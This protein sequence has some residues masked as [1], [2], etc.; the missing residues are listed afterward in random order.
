M[1]LRKLFGISKKHEKKDE[2]GD[3]GKLFSGIKEILE[4]YTES[5]IKLITG[6]AGFLGKVA[7]ADMEI[8]DV[9]KKTIRSVLE[10]TLHLKRGQADAT[11]TLLERHRV[12]LF[13]I[14]DFIYARLINDICDKNQKLE[15]VEAL[16]VVAAANESV[17]AEEDA[18]IRLVCKSLRLSHGDFVQIK[19]GF[20]EHLDVLKGI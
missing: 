12:Q 3:L 14:E 18:S 1:D 20:K 7:Y 4:G 10:E 17:S 15:L 2:D 19:K 16:F 6:F 8:S 11:I 5:D 13:S 9:E